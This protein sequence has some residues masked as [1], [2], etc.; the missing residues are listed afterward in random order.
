MSFHFTVSIIFTVQEKVNVRYALIPSF[1]SHRPQP[2]CFAHPS[3]GGRRNHQDVFEFFT[4]FTSVNWVRL[5]SPI[6]SYVVGWSF[7]KRC[8][9]VCQF[10]DSKNNWLLRKRNLSWTTVVYTEFQAEHEY[11]NRSFQFVELENIWVG[12]I[13]VKKTIFLDFTPFLPAK[14]NS[15]AGAGD[16]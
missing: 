5:K 1:K 4:K 14:K 12:E 16:S 11:Q 8:L 2:C 13:W 7:K 6:S 9:W 15:T 10:S 3:C